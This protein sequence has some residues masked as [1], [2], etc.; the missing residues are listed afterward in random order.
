MDVCALADK[1]GDLAIVRYPDECWYDG[2]CVMA[3]PTQPPSIK[4]VHPLNMRLAIRR[5]R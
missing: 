2:S 5:V 4:L 1:T 3:F